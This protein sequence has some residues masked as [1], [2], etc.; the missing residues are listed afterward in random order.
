M[1]PNDRLLRLA[2]RANA[3]F[4]SACAIAALIGG[5]SLANALAIPDPAFLPALAVNLLVFAGFLVWLSTCIV[6]SPALGWGVV[7]ADA[8]WVVGT[9]PIVAGDVLNGT[10]DMVALLVAAFV[11]LWAVLQAAGIRRM[12]SRSLMARRG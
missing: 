6:I 2:L 4:S 7:V 8:L 5:S 1:T 3:S 11:A 12:T 10:G 9:I